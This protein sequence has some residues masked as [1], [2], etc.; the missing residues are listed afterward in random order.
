MKCYLPNSCGVRP[1]QCIWISN[2]LWISYIC[3]Y[4][5]F[6]QDCKTWGTGARSNLCSHSSN[7][8]EGLAL[9]RQSLLSTLTP[10]V[11]LHQGLH[12]KSEERK[13]YNL[14]LLPT[15]FPARV[16]LSPSSVHPLSSSGLCQS[17]P[18]SLGSGGHA[19]LTGLLSLEAYEAYG[20]YSADEAAHGKV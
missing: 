12:V 7:L 2:Q 4:L 5:S 17:H 1:S 13:G 8:I 10:R 14:Q 3:V 18:F 9:S 15:T 6:L 16:I 11:S 19:W 20:F